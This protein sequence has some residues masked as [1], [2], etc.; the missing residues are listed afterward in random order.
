MRSLIYIRFVWS[1]I[2]LWAG[3]VADWRPHDCGSIRRWATTCRPVLDAARSS[4]Y[5][6]LG[7]LSPDTRWPKHEA[8]TQLRR[9]H[10]LQI[11]ESSLRSPIRFHSVVIRHTDNFTLI[12]T[13]GLYGYQTTRGIS[14]SIVTE[15]LA[16]RPEFDSR[17][18]QKSFLFT[19][20]IP[21]LNFTQP[22]IQWLTRALFPGL[23]RPMR[24]ADHSPPSSADVKDAWSYTSFL[25]YVVMA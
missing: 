14:V 17:R 12:C 20:S 23:K 3:T 2:V 10:R 22:P 9:L 16:G 18:G 24:G 1:A 25:P 21:D 19:A 11:P 7:T 4:G 15:L 8:A 13:I 6:V 5:W